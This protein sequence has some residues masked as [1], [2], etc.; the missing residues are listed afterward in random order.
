MFAV[1]KGAVK[2]VV[3]LNVELLIVCFNLKIVLRVG[4]LCLLRLYEFYRFVHELFVFGGVLIDV[5]WAECVCYVARVA[6]GF[7]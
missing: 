1:G 7:A 5:M 6:V 3:L 4:C 2:V